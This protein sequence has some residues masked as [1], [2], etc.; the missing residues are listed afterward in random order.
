MS[1]SASIAA[2]KTQS[3]DLDPAAP[4]APVPATVPEYLDSL[5]IGRPHVS[6]FAASALG[7]VFDA[8]ELGILGLAGPS[9][10]QEWGLRPS[11]L[12]ILFSLTAAG[13][14]IGDMAWLM[15][16]IALHYDC[17][18]LPNNRPPS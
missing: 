9:I 8:F 15:A 5:P 4:P 7:F 6:I 1:Q 18:L 13:M 16:A 14:L 3:F 12:A 2:G 11:D 10:A 17:T